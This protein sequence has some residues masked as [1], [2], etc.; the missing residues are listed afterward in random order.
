[1]YLYVKNLVHSEN[2]DTRV[3]VQFCRCV[4]TFKFTKFIQCLLQIAIGLYLDAK[5]TRFD[6]DVQYHVHACVLVLAPVN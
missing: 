1:M 6:V 4:F 3:H 2:T 5:F